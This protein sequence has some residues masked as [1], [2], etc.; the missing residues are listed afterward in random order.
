V[1]LTATLSAVAFT[2]NAPTGPV[3]FMSNGAS[4][5]GCTAQSV[6]LVAGNYQ[7]ICTTSALLAGSD[8]IVA[9]YAGDSNFNGRPSA[10]FSQ[11]V[12]PLAA[13]LG[14]RGR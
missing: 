8:A 10:T 4:I 12:S 7:A 9:T 13:T 14:C 5:T 6:T 11:V 2:P 3:G 1:T